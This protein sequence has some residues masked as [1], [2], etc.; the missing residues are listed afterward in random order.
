[1]KKFLVASVSAVALM[2]LVACSDSTDNTTTQSV[3]QAEP[4]MEQP[5]TPAPPATD[6]TTTQGIEPTPETGTGGDLQ[7][8]S[9][10]QPM[11]EPEVQ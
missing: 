7:G 10:A 9:P 2:G 1:M 6:N 4:G 11:P 5:V 3:P 8:T